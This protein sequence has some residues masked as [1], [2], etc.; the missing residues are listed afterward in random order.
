MRWVSGCLG[1]SWEGW[2]I[3]DGDTHKSLGTSRAPGCGGG[4]EACPSECHEDFVC[5]LSVGHEG[6]TRG[7]ER[8][9]AFCTPW[10]RG[11][12]VA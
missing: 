1:T 6:G 11:T 7:G 9:A 12:L 5:A 3:L 8:A 4:A 2:G 10:G